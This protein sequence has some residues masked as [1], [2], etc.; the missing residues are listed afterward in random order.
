MENFNWKKDQYLKLNKS[1]DGPISR[2]EVTAGR[3]SKPED[4][5]VEITQT[6][7]E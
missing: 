3:V 7:E 4:R 1:M 5:S 2:I 6:K